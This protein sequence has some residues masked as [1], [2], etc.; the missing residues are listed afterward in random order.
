LENDDDLQGLTN[1][2]WCSGAAGPL[3]RNGGRGGA[4]NDQCAQNWPPLTAGK[5][6]KGLGDY[7]VIT[8]DDGNLQW[9]YKGRPLYLW[10]KDTKPGEKTGDGVKDVWHVAKP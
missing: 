10:V 3:W 5:A 6:D 7:S 8:R 9:A 1:R 2:P 4:G